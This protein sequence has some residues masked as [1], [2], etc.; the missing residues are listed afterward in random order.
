MRDFKV[1]FVPS[2]V[3]IT[4]LWSLP[5][6]HMHCFSNTPDFA[7]LPFT[8]FRTLHRITGMELTL[9]SPSPLI[10]S[11]HRRSNLQHNVSSD[12][13]C[14]ISSSSCCMLPA[15]SKTK[16]AFATSMARGR[17]LRDL[18]PGGEFARF[19]AVVLNAYKECPVL[20]QEDRTRYL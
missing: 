2:F 6:I 8:Y 1:R 10:L 15:S 7:A 16:L 18:I 17:M 20:D 5:Q 14:F 3:V 9:F 13:K 4:F 11:L 19:D 12:A